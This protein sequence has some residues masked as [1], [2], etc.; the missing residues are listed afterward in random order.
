MDIIRMSENSW[1]IE[2]GEVRFFLLAGNKKA[3][4]IDSGMNIHN[5]KEIAQQLVS[6]PVELLNTHGDMDHIGS[7]GEFD[8]FYMNPAEASNYYRTQGKTG[9]FIPVE[10]GKVLDLGNR[11]LEIIHI[12][13]HTP[14]SIAVLDIDN[15]ILY[16]G[17][18]VQ[19]DVI[20]MFGVQRSF[21]PICIAWKNWR[22]TKEN[23]MRFIHLT[24][25]FLSAWN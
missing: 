15:R 7:N 20:F 4:L 19:D 2:D 13:G 1:R 6:L 3:L 16:S 18:T 10:D 25:P 11:K 5:A 17:D 21:M 23:L 22:E 24:V 8:N 9:C 14:G 12:P